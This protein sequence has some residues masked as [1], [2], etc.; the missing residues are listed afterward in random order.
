MLRGDDSIAILFR[1]SGGRM[2]NAR[3]VRSSN[4]EHQG[5]VGASRFEYALIAPSCPDA[6]GVSA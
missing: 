6:P 4:C 3:L 5:K 2:R 1:S